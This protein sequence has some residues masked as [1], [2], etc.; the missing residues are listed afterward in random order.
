ME[1]AL[2]SQRGNHECQSRAS[3]T[4]LHMSKEVYGTLSWFRHSIKPRTIQ[5]LGCQP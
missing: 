3:G 2:E 5:S 4:Y 1:R